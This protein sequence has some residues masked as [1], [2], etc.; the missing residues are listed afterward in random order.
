[1]N[2]AILASLVLAATSTMTFAQAEKPDPGSLSNKQ[3]DQQGVSGGSTAAPTAQPSGGSLTDKAK[4]DQPG[5]TGGSTGASGKASTGVD[6][7]KDLKDNDTK[8]Q[9]GKGSLSEPN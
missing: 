6:G 9:E 2:K 3:R 5:N 7:T 8:Q 4:A 1:M